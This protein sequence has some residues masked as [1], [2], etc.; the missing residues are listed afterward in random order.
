MASRI[1]AIKALQTNIQPQTTAEMGDIVELMRRRTGLGEGEIW[2]VLMELRDTLVYFA[3]SGQATKVPG[4]GTFTPTLRADG[5]FHMNFHPAVEL[6]QALNSGNFYGSSTT[7]R[8]A[9]K[10]QKSWPPCGMNCIR[11]I[12][13]R[14]ESPQN[15]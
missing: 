11:M 12:R 4:I 5:D 9:A 1:K 13:R 15:G 14:I 3:R 8:T 10:A 7:R 2:Q 6:K